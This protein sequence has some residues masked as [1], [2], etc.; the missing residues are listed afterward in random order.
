M[1]KTSSCTVDVPPNKVLCRTGS[2][3]SV[4]GIWTEDEASSPLHHKSPAALSHCSTENVGY[5]EAE[6]V[7][8]RIVSFNIHGWRDTFHKDNFDGVV[9]SL[10]KMNA[11]VVALQEVLHPYCPPSD[12]AEAAAYFEQ[13][14]SGKGNGF[15]GAYME[16][17]EQKSY[18][19]ALAEALGLPH[20]S[21]GKAV[22]DGYFGAFGYGNAVISRF[23]VVEESHTVVKPHAR[24]QAGRRIE[25]EDR[26]FSAVTLGVGGERRQTV[27]VT[28]LDQLSDALRLEQVEAMLPLA[29]RAGPHVLCG[30]FNVFQKADCA[31]E[32]W[33]AILDDAAGKG[34]GAPPET[35][36]AIQEVLARG[37]QDCFY[38]SDNHRKG[39]AE[40]EL[41]VEGMAED[42]ATPGATCWVIKPLLRIDYA[43]LSKELAA[44][45]VR[46]YQRV[47]DDCSDHFPI[48]VDLSL[49]PIVPA[50]SRS[51][52]PS[53]FSSDSRSVS[54][55]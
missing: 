1:T 30:D 43:F 47:L 25:A 19:T 31:A 45:T 34:W 21:F 54:V 46:Q 36:A 22:D 32:Q 26:C 5:D 2:P 29:E 7:K 50:A 9:A 17:G 53:S 18:L 51:C 23:P 11:D 4:E 8:L 40:A 28:H 33:Q 48:V 16:A 6:E 3:R 44:A 13:V 37:Y 12:P 35:T 10:R 41:A 15:S 55:N 20:V 38:L 39:C 27:C 49:P 42:A 14:K 24:H 52:S